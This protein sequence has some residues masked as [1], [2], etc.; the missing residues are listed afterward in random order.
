MT[1]L[2]ITEGNVWAKVQNE[3]TPHMSLEY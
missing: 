2:M 3:N 1:N